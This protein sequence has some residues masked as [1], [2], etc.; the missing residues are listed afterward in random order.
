MKYISTRDTSVR[1]VDFQEVLLSSVPKDGGLY[2]PE[3]WPQVELDNNH[4]YAE[5][6]TEVISPLIGTLIPKA[7]LFDLVKKSY[8]S[9]SAKEVIPLSYLE[10]PDIYL[11]ELFHGP[12]LAFKDVALQLVGNLF[13]YVIDLKVKSKFTIL[14]ATSGDTGAAAI[15]ACLGKKNLQVIVLHPAG[16]TSDNQR[17][18]MT[19]VDEK[20]VINIAIEGNFDDCQK[21]VKQLFQ[22]PELSEL[23]LTAMNSINWAR[24]ATQAV[25]YFYAQEKIRAKIKQQD[26]QFVFC[27]PSGNFG[28]I[29]S[30]WVA[31]QM[32]ASIARLIAGVN[33]NNMLVQFLK[34][35]EIG[36]MNT[37]PSLAP[38]MD[39]SVPSNLE[40]LIFELTG[41]SAERTKTYYSAIQNKEPLKIEPD[42]QTNDEFNSLWDA[43]SI[44]DDQIRSTIKEVH[45][46]CGVWIDPHTAVGVGAILEARKNDPELSKFPQVV[47]ATAHPAKFSDLYIEEPD[48]PSL[49]K[50]FEDLSSRTE[51]YKTLPLDYL[52]VLKYIK[53]VI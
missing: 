43:Y 6:A 51:H 8:K 16:L 3:S 26:S 4:S 1:S 21:L 19:S 25:Y 14:T 9:F 38:S 18:M 49:P 46:K 28:N 5:L 33:K 13:E 11:M 37:E 50:A 2:V 20:N 29:Y 44:L 48:A 35:K 39:I 7:E 40:R 47:L 41:R 17:K 12:T 32:G 15:Y 10:E 36:S 45:S 53:S 42:A 24:V 52:E 23:N 30:G 31:K 22:E 27:V 34:S